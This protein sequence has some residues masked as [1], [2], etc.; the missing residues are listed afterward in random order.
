MIRV[1]KN[2]MLLQHLHSAV[3]IFFGNQLQSFAPRRYVEAVLDFVLRS[4]NSMFL[5]L[6]PSFPDT[7]ERLNKRDILQSGSKESAQIRNCATCVEA[8]GSK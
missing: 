2:N 6:H 7:A 8:S 4:T 5:G 3:K 1:C